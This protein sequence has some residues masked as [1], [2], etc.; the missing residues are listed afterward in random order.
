[1]IDERIRFYMKVPLGDGTFT[2]G[3]IDYTRHPSI[4]GVEGIDL[5]GMRVLDVAAN[6]G[7]LE[8]LDRAARGRRV[9]PSTSTGSTAR[10][11]LRRG[12]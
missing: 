3:R 11:G 12:A 10:L 5:A 7:V 4:L 9:A 2:N 1:M 6:D 8:L